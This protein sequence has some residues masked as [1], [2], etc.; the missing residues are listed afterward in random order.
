MSIHTISQPMTLAAAVR[1]FNVRNGTNVTVAEVAKTNGLDPSRPV[2]ANTRL[3]FPDV[4]EAG[5]GRTSTSSPMTS[6]ATLGQPA[7]PLYGK[8]SEAQ[9]AERL[10][11]L[12]EPEPPPQGASQEELT[13][14]QQK[15]QQYAR[16]YDMLTKI[17]QAFHDMKKGI[18]S[19]FRV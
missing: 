11:S 10:A 12:K 17:Q 9:I 4:F 8:D 18:I 3:V 14:Y 13:R 19:N 7:L 6:A 1:D 2:P 16:M 15:L 5:G